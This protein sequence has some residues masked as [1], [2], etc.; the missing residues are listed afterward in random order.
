MEGDLV[1]RAIAVYRA[2]FD[3]VG[4]FENSVFPGIED[5]LA[6]WDVGATFTPTPDPRH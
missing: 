5:A 3:E 2:R 4:I 1:D 6:G